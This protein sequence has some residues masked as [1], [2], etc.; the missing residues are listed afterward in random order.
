MNGIKAV[1]FDLDGTLID[2]SRGFVAAHRAV[3]SRLFN[4]LKGLGTKIQETE[5]YSK[6]KE[7]DDRMNLERKYHRDLWWPLLLKELNVKMGLPFKVIGEL[8]LLYWDGFEKGAEPYQDAEPILKYLKGKGY[9]LGLIT[10]TDGVKGIKQGRLARLEIV[11]YFDV[12]V[13]SGEDTPR[14]KPDPEAFHL[15][16]RKLM[17]KPSECVFVGDKPFTDIR[18]GKAA[19]MRTVLLKWRDWRMDD[20]PDFTIKSLAELRDIL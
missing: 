15:A 2:S 12:V 19:G 16:A 20:R 1:L 18:G 4:Y 10:D 17:L 7:V 13:I 14:T 5:I 3:S 9:G 6:L 8:T 11:K